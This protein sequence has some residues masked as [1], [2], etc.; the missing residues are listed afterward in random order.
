M[1]G[2][3]TVRNSGG[4]RKSPLGRNA[5]PAYNRVSGARGIWHPLTPAIVAT[6]EALTVNSP[7]EIA[8]ADPS[9]PPQRPAVRWV[10]LR[11]R[12]HWWSVFGALLILLAVPLRVWLVTPS[13]LQDAL[14]DDRDMGGC[15]VIAGGGR[16][17]EPVMRTFVERA[18]GRTARIVVIPGGIIEQRHRDSYLAEWK[19]AGAAEVQILHAHSRDEA[20]QPGFSTCLESATGV[21]LGGGDQNWHSSLYADT[22]VEQRLKEVLSRDGVV[23]GV[24]AGASVMTRVMMAGGRGEPVQGQ[25]FDLFPGAVIDQHFLKRNRLSRLLSLLERN[26]NLVGFG[27]DEGTALVVRLRDWNLSVVGDSYVMAVVPATDTRKLRFEVL[28]PGDQIDLAG[29]HDPDVQVTSAEDLDE[30]LS[31]G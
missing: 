29:L 31:G 2:K 26:P 15:L 7:A 6:H 9:E 23:G 19:R 18:G 21:W 27:V 16:M 20:D 13:S 5:S 14:A 1:S 4:R 12:I 3:N 10:G 24:S 17:S 22:I 30:V 25:G 8:V 28:K 11:A